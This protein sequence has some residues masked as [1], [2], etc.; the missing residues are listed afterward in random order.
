MNHRSDIFNKKSEPFTSL[1]AFE[2]WMSRQRFLPIPVL[3]AKYTCMLRSGLYNTC[4][5]SRARWTWSRKNT[6]QLLRFAVGHNNGAKKKY[7]VLY[8]FDV[9]HATLCFFTSK[10]EEHEHMKRRDRAGEVKK[11]MQMQRLKH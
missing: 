11:S 4:R 10:T 2:I 6:R 5:R 7:R 1:R 3:T 8:M 9:A